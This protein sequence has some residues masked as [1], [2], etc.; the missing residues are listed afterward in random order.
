MKLAI[1][2]AA[3]NEGWEPK[4]TKGEYRWFP[5]FELFTKEELD[6]MD[7]QQCSRVAQRSNIYAFANGGVACVYA[8]NDSSYTY[9]YYGSHLAFRE[10][11]IAEYAGKQ[12]IET[13]ADF[14]FKTKEEE[15][16]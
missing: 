6:E 15:A 10:K 16:E 2:A 9:T 14:V 8:S 3:L 12:F 7:E 11:A 5:W 13:W 4:F 1:I